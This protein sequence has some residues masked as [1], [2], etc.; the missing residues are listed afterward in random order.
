MKPPSD[1]AKALAR[2][3]AAAFGT[4]ARVTR[5]WDEEER[6]H[7]DILSC[8]DSPWA[9]V[10]SYATLG[11]SEV[12]LVKDGTDLQVR[13]E[14]VGACR[15]DTPGFAESLA[16]AAFC[17]V[18]SRWLVAPGIIFPDAIFIHG[19]S[20]TM[21]HFL[22]LPPFLWED[23]LKTIAIDAWRIAFLMAVPISEAEM[24]FAG[25]EG[26]PALEELFERQQ[27]DVFNMDR[28]SVLPPESGRAATRR[29]SSEP[30]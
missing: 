15:S 30:G 1:D 24:Q 22:F 3:V 6:T 17:I 10:T 16:T 12:A 9:G 20:A 28:D 25:A 14:L 4:P 18:K 11:V 7:V 27:I 5:Y 19:A 26:V 21:R 13:A 29:S 2:A 23:R 8:A